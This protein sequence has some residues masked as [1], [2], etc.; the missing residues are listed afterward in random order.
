MDPGDPLRPLSV[1]RVN[2]LERVLSRENNDCVAM[3]QAFHDFS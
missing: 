2:F 3:R 1:E